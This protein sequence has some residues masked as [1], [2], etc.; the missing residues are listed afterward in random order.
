MEQIERELLLGIQSGDQRAYGML[1]RIYFQAL[2]LYA[3]HN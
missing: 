1:I 2:V 3:N